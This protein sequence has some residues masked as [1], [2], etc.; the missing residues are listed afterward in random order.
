MKE[1]IMIFIIGL[2]VGGVLTTG[3]FLI[4]NNVTKNNNI[5]NQP[6]FI[7]NGQPPEM[8][9]GPQ[10]GNGNMPEKPEGKG[11]TNQAKPNGKNKKQ[12]NTQEQ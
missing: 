5:P 12:N 6:N 9:N 3:G 8:P 10:G 1:K 11:E 2:L 7:E 4:Y